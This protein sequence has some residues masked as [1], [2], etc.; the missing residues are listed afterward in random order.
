MP[1]DSYQF[2][3]KL[4]DGYQFIF[5]FAV[6][7]AEDVCYWVAFFLSNAIYILHFFSAFKNRPIL[8]ATPSQNG[9]L[10]CC[11]SRIQEI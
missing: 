9:H 5:Q 8:T 2:D 11:G 10:V 4:T 6:V 1:I 7:I 3:F